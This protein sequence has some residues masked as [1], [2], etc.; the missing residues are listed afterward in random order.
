MTRQLTTRDLTTVAATGMRS[1]PLRAALSALGIAIGIAAM[2]AVVGISESSRAELLAQIDAL[3]TNLLTVAPARGAENDTTAIPPD[4]PAMINRIP[5]VEHAA[6]IGSVTIDNAPATVHRSNQIPSIETN[7]L[8]V[9]AAP[10][11]LL[12]AVGGQMRKGRFLDTVLQNYPTVVLGPLAANQLG[13]TLDVTPS[14]VWI[15]QR[16]FLV[17]GILQPTALTPEL[18]RAALIGFPEAAELSGPGQTPIVTIY[19]RV[20]PTATTAI[21]ALLAR[22]TNPLHPN[23]ITT[24]RPSDALAARAAADDALTS[25]LVSIGSVALL[26]GGLGVANVMAIAIL[27][28]RNEIGLRRAL[29]ATRRNIATQF[30]SES[31]ILATIGGITGITIGATIAAAWANHRGWTTTLPPATLAIGLAAA[32]TVGALAGLYPALRAAQL[33]PTEA[34]RTV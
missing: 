29:G 13:I 31:L 9:V 32:I 23:Q 17:A 25:L 15:G 19:I 3:G 33:S 7:G 2:V 28:R 34:L 21:Q 12:D 1:R 11:T 14:F 20:K 27:E 6:A 22:T 4:A 5:G 16:N 30:L 8:S 18:D 24:S 26:V 10:P